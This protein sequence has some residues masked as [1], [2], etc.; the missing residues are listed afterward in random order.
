M[1]NRGIANR[2]LLKAFIVALGLSAVAHAGLGYLPLAVPPPLRMTPAKNPLTDATSLNLAPDT[3]L[4]GTLSAAEAIN[5][6]TNSLATSGETNST[7]DVLPIALGEGNV[8]ENPFSPTMLGMAP[9]DFL[10]ISPQMLTTYFH[11]VARGT[12]SANIIAP[13]PVM[14]M[15]PQVQMFQPNS[16]AEFIVK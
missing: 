2:A 11:P 12:N 3:N 16:H 4:V 6:P 7:D 1:K 5:L 15:P 14:F 13:P 8:S 9:P 10:N